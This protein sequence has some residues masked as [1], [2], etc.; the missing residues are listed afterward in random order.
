MAIENS[1]LNTS[2]ALPASNENLKG[3]SGDGNSIALADL[4]RGFLREP[5]PP[6]GLYDRLDLPYLFDL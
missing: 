6:T 3:G 1:E 5:P 2:P 4:E